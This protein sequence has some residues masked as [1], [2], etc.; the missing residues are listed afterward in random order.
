MGLNFRYKAW[1]FLWVL[2]CSSLI[3]SVKA[4]VTYDHKAVI[5]NGQRR[6]LL[7]GSIHY[8]RSTPEYYFEERYDLVK[9]IQLVQ[10]AGLYVHLRI[11]P[12]V[13]AEWNFGGFP[14]WLK[15]VPGMAF[16]TDNEPF[17]A[18][19]QKF[20][21][22]IVGMM[23]Q[24]KLFETQGGPIILSQI[25]NEY[26]PVEWEIG[27]P[28]KAYTKWAAQ[29]AEGLSTGVPWIMCKQ[30]EDVP[31]SIIVGMM[32]QEKLFETQ[33]GPIILSQ[34]ENEYGP[35]EWEIG[36]PGKAY[37][38]WAA[39]MAEG[40]S[41]GVPWIMC[42]QDE[43][44]PDS[45]I[46]TCNGFYCEGFKPK[47]DNKPKMWTENW[48]GWFPEFGGAVPYRPAED[49]AFSVARFI[50]NGGS[51]MNYYMYHGG[52]NFD[53]TAGQ[54]IATSYDYD[55]PLDEYG[56][57]REPKYSHLTKLHK[58]I[59]LCEP[60]LV[61]VDPTVTWLGDKLEAHVFKSESSCAAFLSN[62]NDSYAARVSFWG[63]TY[64]LP[65]WSVSILPDCKTEYYN[66]A[67]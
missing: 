23:K 25:E 51:F 59:K 5:I 16:R 22:K 66:T 36:A 13:C 2:C 64:D 55:A 10:Q 53:R 34:I 27:A 30:D 44:V 38:K 33:G 50:H 9:F 18:A 62:Y 29:M 3:S 49:I 4:T 28:G 47:S 52:T 61:S 20:T 56:L 45:I 7:S 42:K 39:Q 43:D 17:K 32:K 8:P 6:I 11:G 31:D 35:V 63:S 14:V 1:V 19:M 41:T 57:P 54:F 65:P 67:K 37:T 15:F 24:E 48:T 58:V 60:A 21:E 46:N 12:Y 40:L 26:G